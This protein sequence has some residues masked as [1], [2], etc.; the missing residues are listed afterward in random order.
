[1]R[2]RETKGPLRNRQRA[3]SHYALPAISVAG[4]AVAGTI[5]RPVRTAHLRADAMGIAP[6]VVAHARYQTAIPVVII[7]VIGAAI[8]VV[9]VIVAAIGAEGKTETALRR[10]RARSRERRQRERTSDQRR[11]EESFHCRLPFPVAL[12]LNAPS[13]RSRTKRGGRFTV[14]STPYFPD[15]R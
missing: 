3:F 9:A 2:T 5:R 12:L 11:L 15:F 13:L 8:I 4:I 7:A 10:R 6:A 1:M 14:P